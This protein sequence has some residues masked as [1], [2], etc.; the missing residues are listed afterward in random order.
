MNQEEKIITI[1]KISNNIHS[2]KIAHQKFW[3]F[4]LERLKNINIIHLNTAHIAKIQTIRVPTNCDREKTSK[5]QRIVIKTQKT[6]S[7]R[8]NWAFWFLT[9]L[10][11]AEIHVMIR[12]NQRIMSM[13]FQNIDG[14][15]M[16]IIQ[17][18]IVM[19]E[20]PA[21]NQN[22]RTCLFSFSAILNQFRG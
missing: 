5:N 13:N 4:L 2:H 1:H 20:K 21:S 16:V 10:M 9:V 19:I 17:K 15:H 8:I 11:I 12:K 22:G 6:N 3:V 18:I 7:S 14:E